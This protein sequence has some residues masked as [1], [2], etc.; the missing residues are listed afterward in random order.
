V[1]E[2]LRHEPLAAKAPATIE[3]RYHDWAEAITET[4]PFR[5]RRPAR[6]PSGFRLTALQAFAPDH[7]EA[8]FDNLVATYTGQGEAI[9][10]IHQ[11]EIARPDE[12]DIRKTLAASPPAEIA[13]GVLDLH[14]KRAYWIA[15]SVRANADGTDAGWDRTTTVMTWSDDMVGYRIEGRGLSLTA[16]AQIASDFA[17]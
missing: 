8:D 13:H 3:R 2:T 5:A 10:S 17:Q 6:T 4:T 1:S 9:Y 14:G 11:F 16:I 15:G 7:R 12:F